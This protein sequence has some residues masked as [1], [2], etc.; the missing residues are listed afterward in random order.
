MTALNVAIAEDNPKTLELLN[1]MLKN[2]EGINIVGNAETGEDAYKMILNSEPDI[3]LLDVVMPGMDGVEVMEK[4]KTEGDFKKKPSFIMV[5]AAGSENVTEDSFRM[6]AN[7]FIMKPFE[8]DSV[9]EKIRRVAS[10][11]AKPRMEDPE[12][13]RKVKPYGDLEEYRGR[14]LEKDVTQILHE[15][16]VPAHIKG[17]QYLRDAITASV[18]DQDMLSSV[19][20]VLYPNI[21]KKHQTTPSRVE[22]AIRHAI[23]VSWS[24]GK[25]ETINEI[26]GYTVSNG[27]GKPTNSEFIALLSDKI[28][29]DYKRM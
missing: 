25:M 29:L 2:E 11:R 26:F 15:I 24:R 18:E 5:S 20:K 10:Y 8:K 14:N 21:A 12:D 1:D 4:V 22:R 7:Y 17:Y 27:K 28:R 13:P 3:V 6:G 16:G 9:I 23:E 19:T